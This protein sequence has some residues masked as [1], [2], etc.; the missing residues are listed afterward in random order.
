[1][2]ESLE[3][4]LKTSPGRTKDLNILR[5]KKVDRKFKFVPHKK[6]WTQMVL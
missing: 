4:E 1:M 5:I 2:N 6:H 3:K